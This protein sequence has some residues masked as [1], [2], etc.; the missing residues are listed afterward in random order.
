MT[1]RIRMFSRF[2]EK[3]P[4]AYTS[5]SVTIRKISK[6]RKLLDIR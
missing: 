2:V 1:D 6:S 4:I 3:L 5:F